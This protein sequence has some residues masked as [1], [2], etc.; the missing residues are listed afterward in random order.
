MDYKHLKV[1]QI[2]TWG[3][4]RPRGEVKEYDMDRDCPVRVELVQDSSGVCGRKFPKG[5]EAWF[6]IEDLRL[7]Q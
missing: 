6:P 7:V 4:G 3:S 2:V 5:T 1:G